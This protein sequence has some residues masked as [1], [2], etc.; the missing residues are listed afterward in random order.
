MELSW[1]V[2][3]AAG[4]L[5]GAIPFGLIVGKVTKGIDIRQFGSG[6]VGATNTLRTLGWGPSAVV[7]ALDICKAAVSI[8]IA[9]AVGA[10]PVVQSF[11]GV[12]AVVGHCWS[13]YI[14]FNGGRGV[15]SSLGSALVV[16]PVAGLIGLATAGLVMWRSRY[17]SLGS[18]AGT[19]VATIV[20]VAQVALGWLDPG[21]LALIPAAIVVFVR[22]EDNIGR[23]RAGTERKLGEK[24]SKVGGARVVGRPEST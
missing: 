19:V 20:V 12:A 17:V 1:V 8:E 13:A 7:F 2:A 18:L 15:A 3:V 16:S 10:P 11:A 24:A 4:Y 6:K 21:Y 9:R 5:L 14:G 23:L 22:H